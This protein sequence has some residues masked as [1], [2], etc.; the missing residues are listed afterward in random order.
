[1]AASVMT[2]IGHK[3]KFSLLRNA[4]PALRLRRFRER[5]MPCI[6]EYVVDVVAQKSCYVFAGRA[7][8]G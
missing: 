5:W 2:H 1:M 6:L 3:P 8:T 4:P 7:R